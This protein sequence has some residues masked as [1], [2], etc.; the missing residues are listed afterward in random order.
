MVRF[1]VRICVLPLVLLV[2]AGCG[3]DQKEK[4]PVAKDKLP[5]H[6]PK[7]LPGGVPGGGKEVKPPPKPVSVLK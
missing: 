2:T 1:A 5:T 6:L 7:L 4:Q 3:D